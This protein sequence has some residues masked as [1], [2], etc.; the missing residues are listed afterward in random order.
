MTYRNLSFANNAVCAICVL[1]VRLGF[2][3]A[4]LVAEKSQCLW[5]LQLDLKLLKQTEGQIYITPTAPLLNT[6]LCINDILSDATF[7]VLFLFYQMF[8][9]NS[10]WAKRNSQLDR[11]KTCWLQER[12]TQKGVKLHSQWHPKAKLL[13][14]WEDYTSRQNIWHPSFLLLRGRQMWLIYLLCH[15]SRWHKHCPGF[16]FF[17]KWL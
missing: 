2:I 12:A 3:V 4:L 6:Q 15:K 1:F 10:S 14:T 17:A 9:I 7:F 5:A 13:I 8:A 16:H 11:A